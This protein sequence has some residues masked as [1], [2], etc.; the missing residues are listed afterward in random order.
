LREDFTRFWDDLAPEVT[1][2]LRQHEDAILAAAD[3]RDG[4]STYLPYYLRLAGEMIYEQ[5]DH[6]APEMLG[7]SPSVSVRGNHLFQE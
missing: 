1:G 5:G 6:F 7:R 3:E 2:K 4:T